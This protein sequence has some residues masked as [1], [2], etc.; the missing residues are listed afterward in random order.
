[1]VEY[2]VVTNMLTSSQ[3]IVRVEVSTALLMKN[4]VLWNVMSRGCC[5]NRRFGGTY[6]SI[7]YVK[8]IS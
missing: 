1:M 2:L 4:A 5:M 3:V 8:T 6:T 7:T